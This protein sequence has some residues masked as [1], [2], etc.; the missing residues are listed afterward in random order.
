MFERLGLRSSAMGD[1]S[2]LSVVHPIT[3]VKALADMG[4]GHRVNNCRPTETSTVHAVRILT[5]Q[6][7]HERAGRQPLAPFPIIVSE[8]VMFT[9]SDDWTATGA[10]PH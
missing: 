4:G 3:R 5:A 9:G 10:H 7:H 1:C 2:S 8:F 6:L